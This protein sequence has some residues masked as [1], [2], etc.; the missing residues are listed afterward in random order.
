MPQMRS[1]SAQAKPPLLRDSHNRSLGVFV[2][3]AA[4]MCYRLKPDSMCGTYRSAATI[5]WHTP[6]L[7][8]GVFGG[9]TALGAR[10]AGTLYERG[11]VLH[12]M[13]IAAQSTIRLAQI[14]A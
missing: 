10:L 6:K 11:Y 7:H 8:L 4:L 2:G 12:I 5:L 14:W 3:T 13:L 1:F 9:S